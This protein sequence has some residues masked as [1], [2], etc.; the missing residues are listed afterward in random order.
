MADIVQLVNDN[1]QLLKRRN[2]DLL[3]DTIGL[4][5]LKRKLY[6]PVIELNV[7]NLTKP[8]TVCTDVNCSE[9][10][11]VSVFCTSTIT[12]HPCKRDLVNPNL[13]GLCRI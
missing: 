2:R 6:I 5:E 3:D 8:V 7:T 13:S 12:E 4:E 1:I 9:L 11:P 10:Y